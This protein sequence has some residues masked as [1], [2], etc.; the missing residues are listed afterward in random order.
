MI[1]QSYNFQQSAHF[2]SVERFYVDYVYMV[3][4]Y[5]QK[6]IQNVNCLYAN[7]GPILNWIFNIGTSLIPI[8]GSRCPM[9]VDGGVKS[10]K[11]VTQGIFFRKCKKFGIHYPR[12]R[13][14]GKWYLIRV[15][16]DLQK[17]H[18]RGLKILNENSYPNK[19]TT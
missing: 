19:I 16:G 13:R 6:L 18:P 7:I 11:G 15:R 4:A 3:F 8:E 14:E 5:Q 2:Q 1:C 10:S 17:F 9:G 12:P